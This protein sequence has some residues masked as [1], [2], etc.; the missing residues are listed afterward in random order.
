ML[1]CAVSICS[2]K[3][4]FTSMGSWGHILVISCV[5]PGVPSCYLNSLSILVS[6]SIA[7]YNFPVSYP[8][9]FVVFQ[10]HSVS[11]VR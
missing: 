8:K 7:M 9:H 6:V 10:S 5:D 11:E 3:M 1:K 4:S 2:Q